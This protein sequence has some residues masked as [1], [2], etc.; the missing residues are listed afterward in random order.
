MLYSS[1]VP[2]I[3]LRATTKI[4]EKL[5]VRPVN[6]KQESLSTATQEPSLNKGEI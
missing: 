1:R 4:Q 6:R 2:F 3:S 5:L